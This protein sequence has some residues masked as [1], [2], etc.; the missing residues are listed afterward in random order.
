MTAGADF[1]VT[2]KRIEFWEKLVTDDALILQ[3]HKSRINAAQGTYRMYPQY[4]NPFIDTLSDDSISETER[5]MRLI[6][7]I[8]EC[9]LQDP[10]IVDAEVD[11]STIAREGTQINFDYEI[12]KTDG[13]TLTITF[14]NAD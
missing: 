3:D 6:S 5:D 13:G 10:R 12:F 14:T 11:P 2:D 1:K 7:E 8:R 9:A 4:G